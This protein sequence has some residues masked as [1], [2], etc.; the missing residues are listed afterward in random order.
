MPFGNRASGAASSFILGAVTPRSA[1]LCDFPIGSLCTVLIRMQRRSQ[2]RGA[3]AWRGKYGAVSVDMFDGRTLPYIDNFA[4]VVVSDEL[5][6]VPWDEVLRVLVPGGVA[7]IAGERRTKPRPAEI[8]EWTHYMHDPQGSCVASDSIVGPPRRLQ[9]T[10]G[11]RHG[12]SHEHTASVQA[13]VSAGGRTFDVTDLGSRASIQLPSKYTLTARDAFNGTILWQ[14]EIPDWFNHLYPLKSGPAYMP[15]R[16]VAVGTAVYVSGGVGHPLLALDAT[17]GELLQEYPATATT[18]ELVVSD[19]VIFAVVDPRRE[20]F[21]Y[22]QQDDNC[23]T[24][25]DRASTLWAWRGEPYQLRAIDAATGETLWQR[26]APIAPMTL[27]AGDCQV[28]FFDGRSVVA[29]ERESGSD[30]WIIATGGFGT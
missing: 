2:P 29:L 12:R 23:W 20:L 18:V 16:L 4:N 21:D 27:V 30:L 15:R 1:S 8:D 28:C 10:G 17:T 26:T 3:A 22:N 19:G 9:W 24:E 6:A 25:R 13:L 14:R 11:P 5:G 7:I